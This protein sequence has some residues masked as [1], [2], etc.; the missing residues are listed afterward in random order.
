MH[1][2]KIQL[3]ACFPGRTYYY[4]PVLWMKIL[5]YDVSKERNRYLQ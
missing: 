3:D 2:L 5:E 1:Y 4:I